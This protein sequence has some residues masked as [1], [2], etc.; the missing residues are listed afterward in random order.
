MAGFPGKGAIVPCCAR[1]R[2]A[3]TMLRESGGK[4]TFIAGQGSITHEVC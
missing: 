1:Q 3:R 4:T 2:H